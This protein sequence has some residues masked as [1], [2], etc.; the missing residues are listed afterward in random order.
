MY[1]DRPAGDYV[2]S[3][4]T[5]VIRTLSLTLAPGQLCYVRLNICMGF[6]VGHV[7]PELVSD[8]EGIADIGECHLLSS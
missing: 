4:E 5:E 3:T 2:I 1:V 8:Q 6:F 7:W